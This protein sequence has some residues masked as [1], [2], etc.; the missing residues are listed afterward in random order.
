M[1]TALSERV[2]LLYLLLTFY[3]FGAAMMNEF[4][5]YQS[6]ADLGQYISASDFG[7]WHAATSQTMIP[8]LVLPMALLTL[9]AI[10]LIWFLPSTIPRW[11]LWIVLGCHIIA[12]LSTI[13]IQVPI[14]LQFDQQGYSGPL[15]Q[16]LLTTDWIR[17]GA[18]FVEIPVA[19][20][21]VSYFL[22]RARTPS[23]VEV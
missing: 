17:K 12:W 9:V 15:M 6:W 3:C 16:R 2:F 14:E 21:M 4:V 13:L 7:K 22:N 20:W 1:K 8:F 23:K 10:S 18:F 5:E 11:M 19:L